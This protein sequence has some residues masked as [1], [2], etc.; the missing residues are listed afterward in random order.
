MGNKTGKLI[1]FSGIDGS[2]KSTLC[3][4][5]YKHYKN[6]IPAAL[7]SAFG[8]RLFTS[9]LEC[10]ARALDQEKTVVFSDY[11]CNIAWFCDCA[12]TAI[13]QL[14][15]LLESGTTV[16]MD[17]YCLCAKVYSTATTNQHIDKLFPL[18]SVLPKPDICFYLSVDPNI[19]V[20]RISKRNTKKDYYETAEYLNKIRNTYEIFIPKE[21]YPIEW[22]DASLPLEKSAK[23]II[24]LVDEI[25]F[26]G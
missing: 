17:R 1:V 6:K 19:A 13:D 16:F 22:I 18:L 21:D 20:Q 25:I 2:G 15:P 11:L 3:E 24:K 9:E 7:L 23:E 8:T 4:T 12:Y 5:I 14:V 10:I 26:G